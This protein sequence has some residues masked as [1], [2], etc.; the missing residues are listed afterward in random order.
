M[1]N[2]NFMAVVPP[3]PLI[4][5]EEGGHMFILGKGDKCRYNSRLSLT[6]SEILESQRLCHMISTAL[7]LAMKKQGIDIIRINY[8]EAGN[9]AYKPEYQENNEI[10]PY[11]HE[12]IMGR[13]WNAK[14]QVFPEAPYLPNRKTGF[15]DEFEPLNDD[16]IK[17]IIQEME[18][19]EL[20]E[21]YS[22]DR[23]QVKH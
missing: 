13:T 14:K 7:K 19:L 11:Y 6:P 18:K 17:L 21:K 3:D 5:R 16:D 12:H 22:K 20:E 9:W 2:R 10:K 1:G 15:Y 4:S 8:F 23:W